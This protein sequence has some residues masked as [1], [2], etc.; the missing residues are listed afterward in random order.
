MEDFVVHQSVICYRPAQ[1]VR[2]QK[3][4]VFSVFKARA[5]VEGLCSRADA[6]WEPK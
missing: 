6:V 2:L 3:S 5:N 4:T 1:K